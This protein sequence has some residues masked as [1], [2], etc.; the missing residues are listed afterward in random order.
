MPKIYHKIK[1]MHFHEEFFI[2]IIPHGNAK[3]E[4]CEVIF[5]VTSLFFY[6]KGMGKGNELCKRSNKD[7]FL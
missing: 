4:F 1:K 2:S 7:K 5:D 6:A 3:S